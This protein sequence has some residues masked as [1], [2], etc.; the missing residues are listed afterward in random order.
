VHSAHVLALRGPSI[1]RKKG[2]GSGQ[3]D[4][5][6]VIA[7][8]GLDSSLR[9]IVET[10]AST[11]GQRP[12]ASERGSLID[13]AYSSGTVGLCSTPEGIGA[14]IRARDRYGGIGRLG[15]T[16]APR[17][18]RSRRPR[19]RRRA[20]R[21]VCTTR[22]VSR[23]RTTPSRAE[24]PSTRLNVPGVLQTWVPGCLNDGSQHPFE[25]IGVSPKRG[26]SVTSRVKPPFE[27]DA[28][29]FSV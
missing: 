28:P 5:P 10:R 11:G 18:R 24:P 20:S 26:S 21:A 8:Y 29:L 27:A 4:L 2:L 3:P 23:P 19:P 25:D 1:R 13:C 7:A 12:K 9:A 16:S 14:G 6:D 17:A 22:S 15:I